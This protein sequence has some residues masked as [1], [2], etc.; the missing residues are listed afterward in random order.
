MKT[1]SANLQFRFFGVFCAWVLLALGSQSVQAEDAVQLPDVI[2]TGTKLPKNKNLLKTFVELARMGAGASLSADGGR[3]VQS[4]PAPIASPPAENKPAT[5]TDNPVVI[6]TGE[7]Y[8]EELDFELQGLYGFDL[9][10]RYRSNN[11]SGQ[12]FGPNWLS[13]LDGPRITTEGGIVT[14]VDGRIPKYAHMT[15]EDGTSYSF[16]AG[17]DYDLPGNGKYLYRMH[18]GSPYIGTLYYVAATKQWQLIGDTRKWDFLSDGTIWKIAT[19]NGQMLRSYTYASPGK[20]SRISNGFG[21]ALTFTWTGDRVTKIVDPSNNSWVYAYNSNGML[22]SVTVPGTSG[23]NRQYH[24][25]SSYG[26]A[27]LTGITVGG[28]RYSTYSY[29]SA[30]RVKESALAGNEEKDIF[31]YA[32]NQTTVTD[33]RG[34]A[35]VYK[36]TLVGDELKVK[37]ISRSATSTC[38]AAAASTA[39]DTAGFIDYTVDWN[40]VKTDYAYTGGGLL[41]SKTTAVGTSAAMTE[42]NTWVGA[43]VTETRFENATGSAYAKVAY[44]FSTGLAASGVASEVWTD[45]RTNATRTVNY[46]YTFHSNSALETKTV[47]LTL[48]GTTAKTVYRYDTAGNLTSVTNPVGHVTSF[49]GFNGLGRPGT[50]TDPNGVVT[51]YSFGATGLLST[52]T[53]ATPT[54]SRK[55]TY[56]YDAARRLTDVASPTGRI[57]RWRYNAAGRVTQVG[58]A[59][60]EYVSLGL[61]VSTGTETRSSSRKVPSLSGS[62]PTGT[63]S[64][65]FLATRKLDSLGRPLSDVGNDG[66]TYTYSYD[67]NGNLKTRK[68]A[69]A[70]TTTHSYDAQ[71][72]LLSTTAA[73]GGVITY[74]YSPEG[75]LA[76]VK[77]PRNLITSYTYNAFGQ[78]LTQ[79]SPDTG[80]TTYVYDSAGRLVREDRANGTSIA[81]TWDLLGRLVSRASDDATESFKYDQGTYGKGRLTGL[82]DVSTNGHTS[83]AYGATGELLSQTA[84]VA[85]ADYL[86]TWT[87]D[88]AGRLTGLKY[89]R[90]PVLS[91]TYDA[92]GRVSQIASDLGGTWATLADTF[93]YQPATDRLYGW[94]YGNNLARLVTLDTDGRINKLASPGV[95]DLGFDYNTTDTIASVTD[96]KYSDLTTSYTYDKVDRLTGVT[97]SGDAQTFAWDKSG[98]RDSHTRAGVTYAYSTYSNSNRLQ[99][100]GGGGQ[101]R[102]LA[103]DGI[104][105]VT[106]ETRHDG[107]RTYGYDAFNRL[108]SVN[109]GTTTEASYRNNALNQRVR[110]QVNGV[111]SH[112]IYGASGEFL[113]D[114]E[115]NDTAYVWVGNELLGIVRGTQF[116][117]S[118]NDQLGRPELMTDAAKA[119]VW[120]ARNAA[121]DRSVAQDSVGGMNL[122]FPGQRFQAE[123]GLWYNWNRYYDAGIGQYMQSDPIGLAGGINT[124]TYVGGNPVSRIDPSGLWSLEV[125]GYAGVGFTVTVGQNPNGSGFASL[126]VGFGIGSGWSIDPAGKQAGYMPCQCS[127]WTGGLGVFAEAGVHA[128]IAQ[129]GASLDVGET[130]NSCSANSFV[131]PGVK[132]ELGGLG[133]K[134]IAA[135][136]IKAS[137][138]GG[139]SAAGE[140][141]C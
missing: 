138:G 109:I 36:F 44:T 125:G 98:N 3:G 87:Y 59:L 22:S 45:L 19:A 5:C 57:D 139:G 70:R 58:N 26:T 141:K 68:D 90:G 75:F 55:T 1:N 38:P 43:R 16:E 140:C 117:A 130:K 56:T 107:N 133:M 127:S 69:A 135:T 123:S 10:R 119:V 51:T 131:D 103:Y 25:E 91:Y 121:F 84:T 81:Y 71:N 8:K 137:I 132:A 79:T 65:S 62:T 34:Q 63:V 32:T 80:L 76:S 73:D 13:S 7:K 11:A 4:P 28:V 96:A 20:P 129:L 105:N 134:G 92:Y 6:S 89:P 50:S 97:R 110:T 72:R 54:G 24:Y 39:Y 83:L 37:S 41:M 95:H 18:N 23:V 42:R 102:A 64:G 126:K 94:R 17:D 111:A 46:T 93:L 47:S 9:V 112:H 29:D 53:V 77:D 52:A 74:T 21:K 86:T 67:N 136:G 106:S 115:V 61:T 78:K 14:G 40:G 118:H 88:T 113:F 120:R 82:Q 104:G 100:W 48:P 116:Y 12:L 49:S 101:S 15:L 128:G 31:A 85:D 114:N 124:Y 108:S 66:Q 27:L 30:K 99:T 60:S 35:T 122:G 33:A 2:V